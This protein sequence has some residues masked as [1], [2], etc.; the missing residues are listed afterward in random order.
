MNHVFDECLHIFI[1]SLSNSHE[2]IRLILLLTHASPASLVRLIACVTD[3]AV[4]S[5]QILTSSIRADIRIQ[6]TLIYV[7]GKYSN[8]K[9]VFFNE[10]SLFT[11]VY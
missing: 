10:F 11:Q 5:S 7:Y 4:A 2:V 8:P 3:T 6:C 1:I 9:N